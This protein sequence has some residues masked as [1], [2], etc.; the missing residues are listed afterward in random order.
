MPLKPGNIDWNRTQVWSEGGYCARVFVNLAGRE[1][2]G[3]VEQ[4]DYEALLDKLTDRL[5]GLPDDRGASMGTRVFRPREIYRHVNRVPPD[6]IVHFG[7]LLWRSVGSVGYESLYV[8]ENDTGPDDCNHAQFGVFIL[9][10]PRMNIKGL[11]DGMHLLDVAPTLL[12]VAG[13]DIPASMQ[14]RSLLRRS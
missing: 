2:A 4:S 9:R 1:P 12:D 3:V 10:G 13:R 11:V 7:Q 5:E 6:L 8:Q 14:G